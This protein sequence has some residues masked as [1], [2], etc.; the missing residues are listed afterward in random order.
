MYLHIHIWKRNFNS[1][2]HVFWWWL[3]PFAGD[4]GFPG[5][6]GKTVQR[7]W[8]LRLFP[9]QARLYHVCCWLIIQLHISRSTWLNG[10]PRNG[11]TT[12]TKGKCR[13]CWNVSLLR[14]CDIWLKKAINTLKKTAN[15]ALPL[16]KKGETG[17]E[18]PI[19]QRGREGPMGP[20]GEQGPAGFGLK[21]WT[22]K[23]K[24]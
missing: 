4:S 19:G 23:E 6:P 14:F 24:V 11:W 12:G 1:V 9:L 7:K 22:N 18:G 21:G 10:S 17:P 13:C 15:F 8:V 20:R 2:I 3:L 5:L 16:Y